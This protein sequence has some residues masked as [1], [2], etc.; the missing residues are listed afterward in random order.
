[1]YVDNYLEGY[2]IP[3][4][5]PGLFRELDYAA[6]RVETAEYSSK[7]HAPIRR[8]A[9]EESLY[10]RNLKPEVEPEALYYWLFPNLMLN[11]YPDNLQTN[12]ILPLGHDRT[13]TRF[14]WFVSDEHRPGLEEEL[15]RSLEFSDE[16]QQEDI[17][18]CEAVQRG[19]RSNTY[20]SGRYS[21]ARENGLHHF[22]GLLSRFLQQG[23][24]PEARD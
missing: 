22:H 20:Q 6:Y 4:V 18:I 23:P 21:V 5:H 17:E 14:E 7:Q 19:L 1:M 13:L 16:V 15:A 10:R 11:L 3:L 8:R 9:N 12:V 2:H 24:P